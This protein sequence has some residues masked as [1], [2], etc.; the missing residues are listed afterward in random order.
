VT[1]RRACLTFV[2]LFGASLGHAAADEIVNGATGPGSVY[3]LVRP[4]NWNGSLV[5]YAHGFV[6][7]DQP[8]AITDDDNLVISLLAPQGFAVAVSS[9]S[10]TGWV[11]KDA[12]Q[13]THQLL[14]LFVSNFGQPS[15]VYI[16]GGSM[17]GLVAIKLIE[18]HPHAYDGAVA[19]CA[20]AGGS[21]RLFDYHAHARA[22]FDFFYPNVLPGSASNLPAGTDI[23]QDIVLPA[24]TAMTASPLPMFTMAAIEQ[25]PFPFSTPAELANS[26]VTA[27]VGNAG[28][29][30]QLRSLTHGHPFFDNRSTS[31][32][33][34]TLPAPVLQAINAGIERFD[35]SPSA[36]NAL[37]HNYEPSGDLRIPMLMISDARDPVAPAFNQVAYGAAVAAAGAS[38]LLVQRQVP[39]YGH[40]VFTPTQLATA[41]ADLVAW[42]QFG[43][44]PTP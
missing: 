25:T 35:A 24:I 34:A 10:Q 26:I 31:Y 36:L 8:V 19:A 12:A 3:R 22:L 2:L 7:P 40:C 14:G 27:L 39:V 41:F 23:T 21:Q 28:D 37:E 1:F 29:L 32:S 15:S 43:I 11:V 44:K 5:I 18:T 33:S 30:L 38:D 16:G 6:S 20:V 9:F 17:G 4:T 13:R 42:S